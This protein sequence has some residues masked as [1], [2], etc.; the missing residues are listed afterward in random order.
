MQV[1]TSNTKYGEGKCTASS[2]ERAA[3]PTPSLTLCEHCGEEYCAD[4]VVETAELA[5][6]CKA[7]LV[8]AASNNSTPAKPLRKKRRLDSL[9]MMAKEQRGRFV[10]S[11]YS[12]VTLLN[13][14]TVP[15]ASLRHLASAHF[16]D[17]FI[18]PM[19][20]E[21]SEYEKMMKLKIE[22]PGNQTDEDNDGF[23]PGAD[24]PDRRALDELRKGVRII[25]KNQSPH[26]SQSPLKNHSPF[27]KRS[28]FFRR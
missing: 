28:S 3:S 6:S 1:P 8:Y 14:Q 13:L 23:V 5:H 7:T 25:Y 22:I 20:K 12:M 10:T 17:D 11:L 15:E 19:R 16:D 9:A 24:S 27:K 26:K 21:K 18:E 2:Q 4:A